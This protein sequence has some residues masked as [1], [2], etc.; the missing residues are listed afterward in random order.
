MEDYIV[1]IA[2]SLERDSVIY[3]QD[4]AH[5][6]SLSYTE[7]VEIIYTFKQTICKDLI[8]LSVCYSDNSY[9]VKRSAGQEYCF[10]KHVFRPVG[11]R[12]GPILKNHRDYPHKL[13]T[14]RREVPVKYNRKRYGIENY[15]S[16][17]LT[18]Y[19]VGQDSDGRLTYIES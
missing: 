7:A 15:A 19:K 13:G 8:P 17:T 10:A 2:S 4:F 9:V 11:N 18:Q 5:K 12:V 3:V 6:F 16:H 1:F 14:D